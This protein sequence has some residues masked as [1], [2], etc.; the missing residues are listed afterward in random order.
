MSG[1]PLPNDLPS[2]VRE[3]EMKGPGALNFYFT[4]NVQ[5]FDLGV[6][7][8]LVSQLL[9]MSV[10]PIQMDVLLPDEFSLVLEFECLVMKNCFHFSEIWHKKH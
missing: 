1:V 10:E 5:L 7:M 2:F 4:I 8:I 6:R 3:V 9:S